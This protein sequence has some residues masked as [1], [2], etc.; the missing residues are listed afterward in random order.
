MYYRAIRTVQ[1]GRV[2]Y[3]IIAVRDKKELMRFEDITESFEKILSL[4]MQFNIE[5]LDPIHLEEVL[6]D[7]LMNQDV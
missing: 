6:E 3:G 2:S 1:N 4:T 5:E 7:F